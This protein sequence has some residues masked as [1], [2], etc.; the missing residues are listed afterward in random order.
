MTYDEMVECLRELG[1]NAPVRE[2]GV[3]AYCL[4]GL[5]TAA[6][7]SSI[8]NLQMLTGAATHVSLKERQRLMAM[9]VLNGKVTPPA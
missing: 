8:A 1:A 6:D 7:E 3:I 4:A 2:V 5:C 9:Q